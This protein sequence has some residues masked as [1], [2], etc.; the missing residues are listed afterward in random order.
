MRNAA[1]LLLYSSN[2]N[3]VN[4]ITISNILYLDQDPLNFK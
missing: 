1:S 2:L 4:K 3:H